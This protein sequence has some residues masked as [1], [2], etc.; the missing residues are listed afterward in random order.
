[1][2]S[3]RR[4]GRSRR[5]GSRPGGSRR[6]G[7]RALATFV[8][9]IPERSRGAARGPRPLPGRRPKPRP[10]PPRSRPARPSRDSLGCARNFH[11]GVSGP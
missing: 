6:C 3:P 1:A 7:C 8:R 5:P 10:R 2:C 9:W 4:T 11:R